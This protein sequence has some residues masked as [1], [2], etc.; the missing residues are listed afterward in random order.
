MLRSDASG[1]STPHTPPGH[2][3]ASAQDT[4]LWKPFT[5]EGSSR[6]RAGHRY[7]AWSRAPVCRSWGL[8]ACFSR[9]LTLAQP[10]GSLATSPQGRSPFPARQ[11]HQH[12][13]R[14]PKTQESASSPEGKPVAA[15]TTEETSCLLSRTFLLPPAPG[16]GHFPGGSHCLSSQPRKH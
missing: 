2:W 1:T 12:M 6:D 3:D 10:P 4:W 5:A 9:K 8:P 7:G 14:S 15:Q 11:S 16:Q 13:T